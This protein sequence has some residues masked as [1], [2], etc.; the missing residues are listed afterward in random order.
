MLLG[1]WVVSSLLRAIAQRLV[2]VGE[3]SLAIKFAFNFLVGLLRIPEGLYVVTGQ[4]SD[5]SQVQEDVRF[6]QAIFEGTIL[7]EGIGEILLS[8]VKIALSDGQVA[9]TV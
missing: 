8:E 5:S 1:G 3:A 4:D 2:D 6:F 9:Q 7:C